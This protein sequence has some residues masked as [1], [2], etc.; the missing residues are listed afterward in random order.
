MIPRMGGLLILLPMLIWAQ[1]TSIELQWN[2][3]PDSDLYLYRIFRSTTP[4]ATS[5]IDSVQVPATTFKDATFQKGVLYY[6]RLKAVDFSLNA[7]G[8]SD[9]VSAAVPAISGLSTQEIWPPDTTVRI[10]LADHVYDP[11]DADNTLNWN[12]TGNNQIAVSVASGVATL[13]TPSGWAGQETLTFAVNDDQGF[14]DVHKML[15][16]STTPAGEAPRFTSP[17]TSSLNEDA[18]DK[19]TLTDYVTDADTPSDQLSFSVTQAA[20]ATLTI[21]ANE[22]TIRPDNNWNGQTSATLTVTDDVGL[23]DETSLTINVSAVNDAPVINGLPGMSLGQDTTVT[24]DLGSYASDVDNNVSELSWNFSNYSHLTLSFDDAADRLTLGTPADWEGFEYVVVKVTDPGGLSGQDTLVVRVLAQGVNPPRIENF[25]AVRFNEDDRQTVNL[26]NYVSDDDDP[27]QNLY[28][29]A[30]AHDD[31][32]VT[33]DHGSNTAFYTASA[34][35]NGTTTVRMYVRDPNG[36]VDSVDASV[37]VDAVNDA[38]LFSAI[39]AVNLSEQISRTVNLINYTSDVDNDVTELNW[40]T[41]N[42]KNVAVSIES[43]GVATFSVDSSYHGEEQVTLYVQDAGGARDTTSVTVI[44]QNQ[45]LAPGISGLSDVVMDEDTQTSLDVSSHVNDAD[46][47]LEELTWHFSNNEHISATVSGDT[48]NLIPEAD[49]FGVEDIYIEVR[50]PDD[51]VGFDTLTV[52]VNGVNDAP[53]GLS[54]P[55]ITMTGN[56]FET[57]PLENFINEPDG[58][59]DLTDIEVIRSG[60]GFIGYF[61]DRNAYTLT[62]FTPSGYYGRETFLLKVTDKAGLQASTVFTIAVVAQNIAG[63]VQVAYLGTGTIVN[64]SWTSVRPS[65]DYIEYGTS[66]A[67]GYKTDEQENDYSTTHTHQISGLQEETTYHFR[68]VS[69][70]EAGQ[71]SYTQD[72]TFTTGLSSGV[73]VFPLPYRVSAD[74]NGQGIFFSGIPLQTEIIIYNLIGEPVFRKEVYGP[75][76]KWPVQNNNGQAVSSGTYIYHIKDKDGKKITSGKVVIIR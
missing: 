49:W 42:N 30:A 45:A 46:N 28:W 51:N 24:V 19:I 31:I 75:L 35:W 17:V 22:L 2:A 11:D 74:I 21:N 25:P 52:T 29:Y 3:G 40:S 14:T 26:N 63:A 59:Q 38:P 39:P 66:V 44:R 60:D 33:I 5:Q 12:I 6:Y 23:T 71:L 16:K 1:T 36:N 9:E 43:N 48:L 37:T 47:S 64:M 73:N 56:S 34:N 15:V 65:K 67:Y 41:D 4:G 32:D 53:K 72:S 18:T 20:H 50:D 8:Y 70:N 68:I 55:E 27:V 57:L 7:S 54:V 58:P 10:T 62:F 13:T 76:Y 61:V 69:Q